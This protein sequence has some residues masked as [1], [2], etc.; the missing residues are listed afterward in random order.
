[1]LRGGP[2]SVDLAVIQTHVTRGFGSNAFQPTLH[3]GGI[4]QRS[5]IRDHPQDFDELLPEGAD[6]SERLILFFRRTA[7]ASELPDSSPVPYR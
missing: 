5:K 6:G 7:P 2:N 3:R 1:M 4:R